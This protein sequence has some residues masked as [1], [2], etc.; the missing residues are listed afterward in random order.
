MP[1]W[2]D[3]ERNKMFLA[4]IEL[5]APHGSNNKLPSWTLV[6][7]RMES[8]FTGEAVRQQF[9][10]CRKEGLPRQV[11]PRKSSKAIG[12]TATSRSRS[13]KRFNPTDYDDD[14]ESLYSTSK[15][16]IKKEKM[17]GYDH[18]DR[19]NGVDSGVAS[20]GAGSRG[21]EKVTLKVEKADEDGM[22][23]CRDVTDPCN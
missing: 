19:S 22:L 8:G 11:P 14:D 23:S 6:A 4:M 3:S 13:G 2:S 7:E 10:K 17:M 16:R 1:A 9:Q 21:T 20:S 18:E 5:M 12:A 15:K